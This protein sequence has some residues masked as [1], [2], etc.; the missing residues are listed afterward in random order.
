[1]GIR[2]S[3]RGPYFPWTNGLVEVQNKHLGTHLRMFLQKTT[4]D[5]EIQVHMYAY[6]LNSQPL[7]E[8]NVPP[9]E[10]FFHKRP[11]MPLTFVLKL[12]RNTT[13]TCIPKYCSHLPEQSHHDKTDLNPLFTKHSP[14]IIPQWFLAVKTY[15]TVYEYT[16][17]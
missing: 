1:M 14:N 7:S 15:S 4:K 5:W 11:R 8:L 3:P 16:I 10:I 2:H 12:N 6:A 17:K 13:T 9:R